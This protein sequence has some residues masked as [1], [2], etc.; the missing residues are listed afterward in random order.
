MA[1][2]LMA[3]AAESV[4]GHSDQDRATHVDISNPD[5]EGHKYADESGEKMKALVWIGKNDVRVGLFPIPGEYE[6]RLADVP[7]S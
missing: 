5:R 4:L 7:I 1:E 6:H 2:N 3:K